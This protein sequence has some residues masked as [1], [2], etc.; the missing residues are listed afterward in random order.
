MAGKQ[1][2]R[3]AARRETMPEFVARR[4][5]EVANRG[6]AAEMAA[7][8]AVKAAIR[9]GQGYRLMTP[10]E[11]VTFGA[12]LIQR[13]KPR[14]AAPPAPSARSKPNSLDDSPTAKAVGGTL[15]YAAGLAPGA[16]RGAVHTG[17]GAVDAALFAQRL[18]NPLDLLLSPS[19]QSAVAQASNAGRLFAD[20]AVEGVQNPSKVRN[21]LTSAFQDFRIKHDPTVTP[22]A[23][24]LGGEMKRTFALGMNGGELLFDGVSLAAGGGAIRGAAGLGRVA[25]AANATERAYLAA[26]PGIEASFARPYSK[27]LMSH[28]ILNRG[29][30]LPKVL[31]GGPYPEWLIE[32]EL[33][34][35]RHDPGVTYRDL[36]R[37]HRGAGGDRH[38]SGGKIPDKFGGGRWRTEDL[39][40]DT[41]GPLDR[42]NYGTSPYTK[43]VVGPVLVGGVV[44]KRTRGETP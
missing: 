17:Q 44:D 19:G 32:S 31:G 6:L 29:A 4:A 2:D 34:K 39:G 10:G 36:Y 42:L 25:K 1:P 35:I 23:D 18:A 14:P 40:W 28:H 24:T 13:S 16:V 8:D 37:N 20:Y 26:N 30:K 5:R 15:A 38:F 22:A 27:K 12:G 43:G 7:Y 21:D 11:V 41:Y 3:G 9:I 33:N